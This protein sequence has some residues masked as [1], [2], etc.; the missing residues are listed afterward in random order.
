MSLL[1][2]GFVAALVVATSFGTSADAIDEIVDGELGAQLDEYLSRLEANGMS[3]AFLVAKDG[4]VALAKGYGLADRERGV[5]VTTDTVF[6]VGS[7]TKQFTAA[8]ILKLEEEGK[9][10]VEDSIRKHLKELP[11]NKRDVTIHHLLT[12]AS[13]LRADFGGDYANMSA[14]KMIE[15]FGDADLKTIP[16]EVH[17][18]SNPGYSVLGV[19]VQ[20]LS[21]KG[22]EEYLRKALFEPVGMMDTGYLL[23]DWSAD[24]MAHGYTQSG[25]DW[26]TVREK[27]WAEDGPH[28]N[29]RANGGIMSTIGDMYKWHLALQGDAVLSE[30]SKAKLFA[31][32]IPENPEGSSFYG[33]GWAIFKTERDTD[34]IA[35][36]GG[37]GIFLADFRRYVDEDIVILLMTN[38][39]QTVTNQNQRD[40]RRLVFGFPVELPALKTSAEE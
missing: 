5:P 23:P 16:G 34:L 38:D 32:H 10:A 35:H 39:Q 13:G 33:Y 31:R 2:R 29:L 18:Y 21:G 26:G 9:L 40:I 27:R 11:R 20:R 6:T 19:L 14:E 24:R 7:I 4:E 12:H 1:V 25:L 15:K 30:A 28:W 36:N 17:D 3:G 8:G 22:Y 37:N